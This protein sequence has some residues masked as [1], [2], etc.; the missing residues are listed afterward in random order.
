MDIF[1]PILLV[2]IGPLVLFPGKFPPWVVFGGLSLLIVPYIWRKI[3]R[4]SFSVSTPLNIPL[5]FLLFVLLPITLLVS[6]LLEEYTLPKTTSLVWSLAVFGG[7]INWRSNAEQKNN[8]RERLFWL[9]GA[10]TRSNPEIAIALYYQGLAL[11]PSDVRRWQYLGHLLSKRDP[12]AALGAYLQSCYHGD[13]GANGCM[14]TGCMA[15]KLGDPRAA[16]QYYRLSRYRGALQRADELEQ[17]LA[18]QGGE[19]L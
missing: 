4:G 6:P 2:L 8:S 9:T 13:P 14:G 17:M 16:I 18:E 12:Q 15:E 10:Y 1:E 7:A 3:Q 5:T 19:L 11:D